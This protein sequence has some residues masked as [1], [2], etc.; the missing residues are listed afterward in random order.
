MITRPGRGMREDA[1]G[2]GGGDDIVGGAG[3][4]VERDA[5]LVVVDVGGADDPLEHGALGVRDLPVEYFQAAGLGMA[6]EPERPSDG[7]EGIPIRRWGRRASRSM[8]IRASSR[9]RPWCSI[10]ARNRWRI[11][12]P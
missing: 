1:L 5:A 4:D 9:P 3:V 10:Q 7:S 11:R 2:G 6:A 8:R 12:P